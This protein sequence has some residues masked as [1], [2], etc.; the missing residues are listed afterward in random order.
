MTSRTSVASSRIATASP[1][2]SSFSAGEPAAEKDANTATITAAALVIVRAER[3][4][5]SETAR[6]LSPCASQR[7]RIR[8][9]RNTS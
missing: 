3:T 8:V 1:R 7:S 4:S 9:S 6:S 5:P 2:P